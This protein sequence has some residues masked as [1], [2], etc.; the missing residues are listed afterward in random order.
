MRSFSFNC[1]LSVLFW[2][3]HNYDTSA[4]LY[5]FL[6]PV[7]RSRLSYSFLC[8][9]LSISVENKM[10]QAED[11]FFQFVQWCSS[12]CSRGL[13]VLL[14][15]VAML[16]K[17]L[18]LLC[19]R[20]SRTNLIV[21]YYAP[22]NVSFLLVLTVFLWDEC[23]LTGK[24]ILFSYCYYHEWK[25]RCVHVSVV[26]VKSLC[27]SFMWP[28][29][30]QF[31]NLTSTELPMSVGLA[32]LWITAIKT[33]NLSV[34]ESVNGSHLGTTVKA[35]NTTVNAVDTT[36][37][38]VDTNIDAVGTTVEAVGTTVGASVNACYSDICL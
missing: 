16:F 36:I 10:C 20:R 4:M 5:I 37:D 1:I 11:D 6:L 2:I 28:L 22:I 18:S 30:H 23:S 14:K 27:Y 25:W 26:Y 38:A 19:K 35:V 13:P 17:H 15:V 9:K 12:E 32:S 31:C 33:I 21:I 3:C 8:I 7:Q 29:L 34:N 24:M